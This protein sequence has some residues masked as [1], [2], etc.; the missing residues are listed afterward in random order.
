MRSLLFAAFLP[1]LPF[2]VVRF[3]EVLLQGKKQAAQDAYFN[4]NRHFMYQKTWGASAFTNMYAT[5]GHKADTALSAAGFFWSKNHPKALDHYTVYLTQPS[6]V[7]YLL[8]ATGNPDHPDLNA[9]GA[10][11]EFS[12]TVRD[13][14][15]HKASCGDMKRIGTMQHSVFA[16]N[17]TDLG[18]VAGVRLRFPVD[19]KSR[20]KA[21]LLVSEVIISYGDQSVALESETGETQIVD[22]GLAVRQKYEKYVENGYKY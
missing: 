20:D 3:Q 17:M 16:R 22:V 13:I 18:L 6:K 8:I 1:E 11:V 2:S 5:T 12:S 9:V 10:H 21:S 15:R 7:D 19:Y 4:S 14:Q